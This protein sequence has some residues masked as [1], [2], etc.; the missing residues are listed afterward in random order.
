[1]R[2]VIISWLKAGE[3]QCHQNADWT[4]DLRREAGRQN[5]G[6][7]H[8][9]RRKA[10]GLARD[11]AKYRDVRAGEEAYCYQGQQCGARLVMKR[12]NLEV[13]SR[14]P[15]LDTATGDTCGPGSDMKHTRK[16]DR[17]LG[18]RHASMWVE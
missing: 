13:Q 2:Q 5:G 17:H 9:E 6:S 14:W 3:C 16:E 15:E 12:E 10:Q 1:M 18:T 8:E 7:G 11:W 4:K